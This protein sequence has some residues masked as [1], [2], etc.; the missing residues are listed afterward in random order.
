VKVVKLGL[1]AALV[2]AAYTGFRVYRPWQLSWGSSSY[3]LRRP[4]PGD[5]IVRE[6][7][8]N[9]TRAVTVAASPEAIWP[10][11]VQIGFGRGGWY[12]YD[13]LDNLGR[14][15]AESLVPE[16]QHIEVGDLVP[17]GPGKNSG[18]RVKEFE[19]A[20]W[21]VWWD[22]KLQL[23]TWAWALT[24]MPDGSTRIV[25][26][27]RS[28]TSWQHPSTAIWRLLSEMADFPM[29]R[30]CLLG[31]KRRAETADRTDSCVSATCQRAHQPVRRPRAGTRARSS[32]GGTAERTGRAGRTSA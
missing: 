27:V 7:G 3:E 20:R 5:D 2:A 9:A 30:K 8:F 28:R 12:S 14:R 17:L 11:I 16:L 31:I 4:M 21:V 32:G 15:S 6:P 18:M 23:T 19:R 1:G 24:A 25:T 29:M 10:W 13:L 26:R 22:E